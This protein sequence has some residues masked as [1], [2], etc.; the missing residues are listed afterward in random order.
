MSFSHFYSF[1]GNLRKS[2]NH[3]STSSN[4][5]NPGGYYSGPLLG[6]TPLPSNPITL[7]KEVYLPVIKPVVV[8]ILC[9]N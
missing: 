9:N 6:S 1:S 2:L 3:T 8:F 5:V 7:S 4:F